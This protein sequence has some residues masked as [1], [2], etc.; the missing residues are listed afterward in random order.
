M[1]PTIQLLQTHI[2]ILVEATNRLS[3]SIHI[4]GKYNLFY[5]VADNSQIVI[6]VTATF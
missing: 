6:A 5:L 4:I 2:I 1:P 3:D